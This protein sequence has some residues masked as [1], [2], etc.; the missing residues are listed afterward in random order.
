MRVR[1]SGPQESALE[2]AGLSGD[3]DEGEIMVASSWRQG[4]LVFDEAD[5]DALFS[6]VNELSNS[7]DAMHQEDGDV[8]AGRAA[9]SL[10]SLA[11][12]IL[13]SREDI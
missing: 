12:K 11:S 6:A 9:R 10:S 7:E 5:R 3:L 1:L 2:C 4:Y 13:R 8:Y